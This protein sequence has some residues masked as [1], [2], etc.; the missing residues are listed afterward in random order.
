MK[1]VLDETG[2]GNEQTIVFI[3][4]G[5]ISGWMWDEQVNYFKNYHCIIPDLPEHGRSASVKPFSIPMAAEKV[6]E[7]IWDC[8]EK[9]VN[10]VGIGL[11]GQII[12][13]IMSKYPDVVHKAMVSGTLVRSPKYKSLIRHL[14]QLLTVY[15]PVKNNDF[16]IKAYMRTYN[17]PRAYFDKFKRSTC[18]IETSSIERILLENHRFKIPKLPASSKSKLLVMAGEKDY[19]IIKDS[20]KEI[21][22]KSKAKGAVALGVGHLWN[23]ETPH[24]FNKVLEAW[25]HDKQLPKSMISTL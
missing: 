8:G 1:L 10:L 21:I 13:Q 11:G 23:M 4:A 9:S 20:T 15:K 3:H 7:I 5:G 19:N 16:Y 17:M 2:I 22:G 6:M 24:N 25:I 18:Q 14:N 12:L